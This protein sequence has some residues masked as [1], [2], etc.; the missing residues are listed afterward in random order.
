MGSKRLGLFWVLSTY[1]YLLASSS[2]LPRALLSTAS[3][4]LQEHNLEVT[5]RNDHDIHGTDGD[6]SRIAHHSKYARGGG[7]EGTNNGGSNGKP[8]NENGGSNMHIG[9]AVIPMIV[10]G[11]ANGNHHQ[12]SH[13]SGANCDRSCIELPILIL[14]TF[15][16]FI[17]LISRS[18]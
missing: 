1:L 11:A 17:S 3:D 15:V 10:A 9:A 14:T 16:S 8:E 12:N 5:G 2:P 4:T 18:T 6:E 13:H 7:S